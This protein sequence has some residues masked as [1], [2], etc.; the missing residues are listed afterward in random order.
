MGVS[1]DAGILLAGGVL[2]K[3][4]Y[5]KVIQGR[6]GEEGENFKS[7]LPTLKP[8]PLTSPSMKAG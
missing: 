7:A 5:N 1:D 4:L 2:G 8:L 3:P 6:L